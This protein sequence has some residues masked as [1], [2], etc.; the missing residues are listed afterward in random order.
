LAVRCLGL[1]GAFA[2]CPGDCDHWKCESGSGA[3]LDVPRSAKSDRMCRRRKMS[4]SET[5]AIYVQRRCNML[6]LKERHARAASRQQVTTV[7]AME[8]GGLGFAMNGLLLCMVRA[9]MRTSEGIGF[10]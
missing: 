7:P 2:L 5:A 6:S 1:R 9:V 8:C 3:S 10:I 4:A